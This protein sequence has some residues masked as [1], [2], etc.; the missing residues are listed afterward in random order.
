MLKQKR[1]SFSAIVCIF[2]LLAL[3]SPHLTLTR[4]E[5]SL[6]DSQNTPTTDLGQGN[7]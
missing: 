4:A 7:P 1:E 6:I 5:L 2:T 3:N